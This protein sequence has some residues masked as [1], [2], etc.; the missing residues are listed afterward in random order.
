MQLKRM[1]QYLADA[2]MDDVQDGNIRALLTTCFTKPQDAVFRKQ[3]Y[4]R[5]PYPHRWVIQ[6]SRGAFIA[7][8][9]VHDKIVKAGGQTY[10]IAGIAEVCVHPDHRGQG[11]VQTMLRQIHRWLAPRGFDFAVLFGDPKVY[12]S[13][14]YGSVD[15]LFCAAPVAGGKF[16]RKKIAAMVAPLSNAPWPSAKVFLP[17][18]TF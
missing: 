2:D 15:N 10:R 3:R 11:L 8:V 12:A 5:E 6:D 9:G 16:R 13:S 18:P 4:F 7:H 17:G 14:G 1:P